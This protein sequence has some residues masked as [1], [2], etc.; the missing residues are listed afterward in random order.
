MHLS[1]KEEYLSRKDKK[2]KKIIESNGHIVFKPKKD[3]QFDSLVQIVVAQFI[4]T[5]AADSIFEKIKKNFKLIIYMKNIFK[6]YLFLK[7][8]I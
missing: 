6:T 8:K 4:S 7:L 1:K 2:L 5:S 3:N